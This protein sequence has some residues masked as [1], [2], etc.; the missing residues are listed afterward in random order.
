VDRIVLTGIELYAYGGATHAER[1]I[2]Q[3]YSVDVELEL[4]LSTA[5]RSDSLADTVNYARVVD[6]VVQTARERKFNLLESVTAR[7]ADRLLETYP[8]SSV[9]VLFRKLLPPIDGVVQS[10]GVQVTR[11]RR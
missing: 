9:T 3:R 10:A 7:V 2:G 1:E 5:S 11:E 6:V 4:D 8:V